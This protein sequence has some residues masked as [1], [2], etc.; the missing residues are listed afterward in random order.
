MTLP[1]IPKYDIAT[2]L[3]HFGADT[4]SGRGR[5]KVRCPF[6]HDT[7]PSA[8]VDY[9]RQSFRCFGCD[10]GG[11][12]IDLLAHD[13][14]LTNAAAISRAATLFGQGSGTAPPEPAGD[15]WLFT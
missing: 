11:D 2:A 7:H 14:G 15:S 6:H 12:A 1:P 9:D 3:R 13:E 10:V 4:P 8:V 5:R